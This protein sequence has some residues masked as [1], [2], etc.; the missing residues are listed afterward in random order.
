[1]RCCSVGKGN[2]D[3]S[4]V[5]RVFPYVLQAEWGPGNKAVCVCGVLV[6]VWFVP[7]VPTAAKTAGVGSL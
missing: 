3:V 5:P 7:G 2:E 6:V 4:N 1:M